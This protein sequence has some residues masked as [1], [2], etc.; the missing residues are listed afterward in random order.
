MPFRTIHKYAMSYVASEYLKYTSPDTQN[1][2]LATVKREEFQSLAE[3]A[4]IEFGV[5]LDAD[6]LLSGLRN[7]RDIEQ[8]QARR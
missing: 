7:L 6:R 3:M 5:S 1:K 2:Y 8:T 4:S